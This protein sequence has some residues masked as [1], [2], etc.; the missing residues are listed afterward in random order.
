MTQAPGPAARGTGDG[1][2]GPDA[3]RARL[4][5]ELR[6]SGRLT[7]RTVEAAFLAVPRHVF[8]PEIVATEAY[9]DEAFVIKT[10]DDGMPVSSSSQ[11]AIM[12]IML[13][14]L[15]LAPGHRVLEIGTGTG[16]N[17]ALMAFLVGEQGCVVTVDID[18]D[19]VARARANLAAAGFADVVV[20]CGDGGFGAPGHAPYDR[21]I[22]TA[23]AWDLA[24]AWLAQLGPGG[25]IVL[26]LSVRGI[27][28]CVALERE[29]GHWRSRSACR[30]GFIRMAGAFAGPESFLPLGPQPGLHVQT[31]EGRPV[32]A[33]RLYSVLNGPATDVPTD[34]PADG[35][36]DLGEADLWLTVTEPDLVR[37]TITG[38]GTSQSALLPLMPFGALAE[39]GPAPEPGR[40]GDPGVAA[41]LP[42]RPPAPGRYQTGEFHIAV[43]GFGPGGADLAR[44]LAGQ[45]VA[46]DDLGRPGASSL[47]LTAYPRGTAPGAPD[48]VIPAGPG[49][50]ILDRRHTRLALSWSAP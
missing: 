2:G 27:Q 36:G 37:L 32:D 23:G 5:G 40:A 11:P 43:R 19:L 31:D 44:Y 1:P 28:L 46:W 16:F 14:G 47:R 4:V 39:T 8:L 42:L 6:G 34:V 30:C 24:P 38:G 41:L 48:E 15:G 21:I 12:A 17:A 18:A 10:G 33:E 50:V 45:V 29:A 9:Q 25:R 49:Q 26:P 35:L 7:S 22:V 20:T 13:E 3:A